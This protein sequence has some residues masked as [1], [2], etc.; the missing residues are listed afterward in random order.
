MKKNKETMFKLKMATPPLIVT[1]S[2]KADKIEAICVVCGCTD[3]NACTLPDG[4]CWWVNKEIPLCSNKSCID[5]YEVR[6]K[7]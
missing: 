6:T 3:S 1:R 4:P 5:S 7:S 2:A